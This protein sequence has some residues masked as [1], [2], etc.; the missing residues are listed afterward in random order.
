M[1]LCYKSVAVALFLLFL[2]S[3]VFA[4][5]AAPSW[6]ELNVKEKYSYYDVDG[7][8]LP[9]LRRQMQ[10]GG[11]KW[12]DGRIY[13]ALTS[14]DINYSYDVACVNGRYSVKSVTTKVDIVYHLPRMRACTDPQLASLWS[15]YLERLQLHEFG[16]KDLAIRAAS[17]VNEIFAAL[18]SYGSEEELTL[19]VMRRTTD[20]FKE[21]KEIQVEYDHET[22]HGETQGAVLPDTDA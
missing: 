7:T 14:W 11:T 17:E 18:P 21:L 4:A 9:E 6:C 19:E 16:H 13:S 15:K 10:N 22:R 5:D 20:K 1:H 8:S 2:S 3:S 12:N